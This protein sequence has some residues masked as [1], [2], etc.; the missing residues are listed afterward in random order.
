M[1]L[2]DGKGTAEAAETGDGA[3]GQSKSGR[4]RAGKGKNKGNGDGT[5]GTEQPPDKPP[6][7]LE[8]A[9]ALKKSVLLGILSR[10]VSILQGVGFFH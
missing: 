5:P 4:R 8:K 7:P 9:M 1:G 3:K 10:L 2:G 6:T